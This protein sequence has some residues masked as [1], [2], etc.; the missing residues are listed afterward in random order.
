[1]KKKKSKSLKK[2]KQSKGMVGRF[3]KT[4]NTR[5]NTNP[6]YIGGTPW[7]IGNP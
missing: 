5:S 7:A 1:M 6:G 4:K 2:V 3:S